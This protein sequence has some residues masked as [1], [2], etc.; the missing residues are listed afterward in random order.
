MIRVNGA[1]G[2][3]AAL[4]RQLAAS[5]RAAGLNQHELAPLAG[6]SRSTI[7]NAETGRQRVLRDFWERCDVALG[8]GSALAR[9]YDEVA[10]AQRQEQ[11]SAAAAAR[12]ARMTADGLIREQ[13]SSPDERMAEA[14]AL[15]EPEGAEPVRLLLDS[16]LAGSAADASPQAWDQAVLCHGEATRLRPPG[17]LV[18]VLS[19]D[20]AE[21]AE[22][23]RQCRSVS[24]RRQ[25]V[26]A[27]AQ[28]SGLMCL[29]FVRLDKHDAFRR[30]A[31][32]A[33]TAAGEAEDQATAAWVLAQEAHGHFY[34]RDL[35]GAVAAARQAQMMMPRTPCVG[36]ALASALEARARAAMADVQGTRAALD[37]AEAVMSRLGPAAAVTSAFGYSESQ[38]RFHQENAYTL[39]RDTRPALRA[40]ERALAVCPPADYTDWALI[41]LDRATCLASSGEADTAAAYAAQTLAQVG[42]DRGQGIIARRGLDVLHAMPASYRASPAGRKFAELIHAP[43][44]ASKE[45]PCP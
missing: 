12:Q 25:L 36:T 4:G 37:R 11:L 29:M 22:A 18:T 21:L 10:A 41:R 8:T 20:M 9:G 45:P 30:W 26:R 1:D 14:P 28:L 32:T 3:W 19:A 40:Q 15:D 7:A 33:R 31:Q 38:F 2:A 39:L 13:A 23:I 16:A 5:R 6:Y 34:A 24:S 44:A 17:E 42:G 27:A 43:R 35:P